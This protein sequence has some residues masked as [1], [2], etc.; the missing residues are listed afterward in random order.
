MAGLFYKVHMQKKQSI[1]LSL[2]GSL[3]NML[4]HILLEH[5]KEH[6]RF[7]SNRGSRER[8]MKALSISKPTY[9]RLLNDLVVR[10]ILHKVEGERG[11]YHI[12]KKEIEFGQ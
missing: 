9:I 1:F 5:D 8:I 10:G 2:G 4:H 11:M 7:I 12:N 3:P 6:N